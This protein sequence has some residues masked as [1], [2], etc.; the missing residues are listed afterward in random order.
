[1]DR[2]V[3]RE[4]F[5]HVHDTEVFLQDAQKKVIDLIVLAFLPGLVQ[6][7]VED[8]LNDGFRTGGCKLRGRPPV[9]RR[10]QM[11]NAGS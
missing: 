2:V 4:H 5:T 10:R 1:M 11:K 7:L 3:G 8:G 9:A 6:F